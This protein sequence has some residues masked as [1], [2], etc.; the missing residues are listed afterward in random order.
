[1]SLG[2]LFAVVALAVL[3]A[4]IAYLVGRANASRLPQSAVIVQ[5]IQPMSDLVTVKQSMAEV[6][7][8]ES[9]EG[10]PIAKMLGKDRL[11]LVAHG[12]VS[13]GIDFKELK[14]DHV[15]VE[16]DKV[17]IR[18]PPPKILVSRIVE[19][20]TYVVDRQ[21]GLLVRFD[22]DLEREARIFAVQHFDKAARQSQLLPQ[23]SAR[24]RVIL[25]NLLMQL[26]FKQVTIT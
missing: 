6:F 18:L 23:A 11:L 9:A 21:T 20:R 19:D 16:G 7:R 17:T 4:T 12:E 13:A 14:A 10:W 26:G 5:A 24:A 3:L 15:Q 2:K 22:K 25:E 1:M 8:A